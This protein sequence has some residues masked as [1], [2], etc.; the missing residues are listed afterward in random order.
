[1]EMAE[2]CEKEGGVADALLTYNG[3]GA[4]QMSVMVSPGRYRVQS[5]RVFSS[6]PPNLSA[7]RRLAGTGSPSLTTA[8]THK[9]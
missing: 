9:W 2:A 3:R 5:Q 1:M 6:S 8:T 4:I 7:L